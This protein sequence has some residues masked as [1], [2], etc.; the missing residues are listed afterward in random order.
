MQMGRLRLL[1]RIRPPLLAVAALA[2]LA[3][4]PC[5]AQEAAE[6]DEDP[7]YADRFI[8]PETP[9]FLKQRSA[10]DDDDPAV[11]GFAQLQRKDRSPYAPYYRAA[12]MVFDGA[13]VRLPAMGS[14]VV[15][16]ALFAASAPIAVVSGTLGEA[17]DVFVRSPYRFAIARP[18]GTFA[19]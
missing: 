2:L 7:F 17:L 10:G 13:V 15:G 14:L 16:S 8:V 12:A 3:P 11:D 6:D 5:V 1:R 19:D 4:P 18:L 9:D